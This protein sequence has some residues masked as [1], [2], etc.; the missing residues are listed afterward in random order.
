MSAAGD[1]ALPPI[2]LVGHGRMGAALFD[3]WAG[4]ELAPSVVLT[5][6]PRP[7][8]P[9]PHLAAASL[10]AV[11][12]GF[13]PALIVLAVKPYHAEEVLP[14]LGARFPAVPMLSVMAGR[15]VASL[16]RLSGTDA[17][18]RA[19]PNTPAAIGHGITGLF[20]ARAVPAETR[21]FAARL[22][23]L[24]GEVVS[25]EHEDG[26]D[27]VTAISGSGPAYV[28]LLAELLEEAARGIGLAPEAAR[29]LARATISGAGRLLEADGRDAAALR[30]A[31]TS[32][33]GTTERAVAVLAAPDA[34]PASVRVAVGAAL[35]QARALAR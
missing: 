31:V 18:L 4:A 29:A 12:P 25:L 7:G 26:I 6:S 27:Q 13:A 34:W 16:A 33:G 19:M 15:T 35:E 32:K 17:I 24:S 28:F 3:R 1:A 22:L 23:A 2:L 9:L 21:A 30:A 10:D 14:P 5:P 8:L 20:A 11:P